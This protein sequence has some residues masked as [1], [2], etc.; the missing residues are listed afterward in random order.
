MPDLKF[1]NAF[2][3]NPDA[4][5]PAG[6]VLTLLGLLAGAGLALVAAVAVFR[7]IERGRA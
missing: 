1:T 3:D 2:A 5:P 6:S 4:D 7:R